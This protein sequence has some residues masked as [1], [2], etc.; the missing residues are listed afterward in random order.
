MSIF[1]FL[2]RPDDSWPSIDFGRLYLLLCLLLV[3]CIVVVVVVIIIITT[4]IITTINQ[5]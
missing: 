5:A 4:I 2:P 3:R 1:S